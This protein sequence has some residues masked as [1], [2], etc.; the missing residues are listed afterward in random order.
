MLV[1]LLV[2]AVVSFPSRAVIMS[3]PNLGLERYRL[4]GQPV[5]LTDIADDASGLTYNADTHTLFA[6]V[7]SP[8]LL[9]ELSLAGEVLRQIP[10]QGFD[11][12]EGLSYLGDG[13]L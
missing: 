10:L 6:V 9:F 8:A 12:T 11:D 4:Q 1:L 2:A 7:N 3:G 5:V 13:Q